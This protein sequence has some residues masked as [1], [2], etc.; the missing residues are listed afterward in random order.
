LTLDH[1]NNLLA[2]CKTD[3]QQNIIS[4]LISNNCSFTK[5]AKHLSMKSR[6]IREVLHRVEAGAAI[7]GYD[8]THDMTH[9][10]NENYIVKGLS[11]YYD[12]EGVLAGQWVKADLDLDAKF[13]M[14]KEAI[15]NLVRDIAGKHKPFATPVIETED[16]LTVY[17]LGDPHIGMQAWSKESGDDFDLKI[18]SEDLRL[19]MKQ[20]VA[21]SPASKQ[22]V[23]VDLGDYFHS[24][25]MD[26]TTRK[27]G[28]AL[29][30]DSRWAKVLR[31]GLDI[32]VELIVEA[33]KK[34]E[35]VKVINA[36]GNHNEHSAIFISAFLQAWF[37]DEPRVIIDENPGLFTYHQ[38]G[39]CL[40]GVTHGHTTKAEALP[41]IMAA[42][43]ESIWSETQYRIWLTGHVHH[44][45]CKEFRTCTVETFRTL[46]AKD[47]WH[48]GQGYRSGRD[49][50]AIIFHKLYGEV[51]RNTVNVVMLRDLMKS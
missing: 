47:A 48:A 24:D 10:T 49:M 12:K 34:H 35:T 17:T 33:L 46:A 2:Y 41:E 5:S 7:R 6:Q 38:F 19:A 50:K 45:Q 31:I 39:K 25:S 1:L 20:L 3:K 22:A 51:Q 40:I 30:V 27:S 18:V 23:I 11:S 21:S 29:D 36:I 13:K 42:D 14:V 8:P 9:P 44:Q 26:N 32:M 43:C 37:R 28:N 15:D 4:S 16:L